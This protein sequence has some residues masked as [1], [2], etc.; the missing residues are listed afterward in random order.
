MSSNFARKVKRLRE[1]EA[2]KQL[3]KDIKDITEDGGVPYGMGL[4]L[5]LK[6]QFKFFDLRYNSF[7]ED[8]KTA[9]NEMVKR[10]PDICTYLHQILA[11]N[12]TNN[13]LDEGKWFVSTKEAELLLMLAIPSENEEVVLEDQEPYK[14]KLYGVDGNRIN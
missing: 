7:D 4:L 10:V 13:V 12:L 14:V 5:Y 6:K 11:R 3:E 8:H 2:A 1:Q 9:I